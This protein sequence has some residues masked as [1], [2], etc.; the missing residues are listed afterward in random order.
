MQSP[1]RF[2]PELLRKPL[3]RRQ[4]VVTLLR[5]FALITYYVEPE[6]IRPILHPRFRPTLI[7]TPQGPRALLSVVPFEDEG[8]HFVGLPFLR[9]HF[10]QTNYRI[11]VEDEQTGEQAVWFL[12]TTLASWTVNIPHY[13]W[14]LPWH[15]AKM[16]FTCH[17]DEKNRR[18][19]NYR[20]ST[21]SDWASAELS[22]SDSG[23]PITEIAG[24]DDLEKG[25]ITLT[26]PLR[27]YY[28]RRDGQLGGYNIW[29]DQLHL[30]YG[31]AIQA[32]FGL[33]DRLGLVARGDLSQ[34]HSVMLQP[35]T[36]FAIYLPPKR[37]L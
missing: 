32:E 23:Q 14:K 28:W 25:L 9:W 26:H 30:T 15:K 11:Y 20:V 3:L 16:Q 21:Q 24:F 27:G 17:Y 5:H 6:K 12:G 8:F 34:I 19:T 37:I 13:L 31:E 29:H 36:E 7:E 33:P 18:Y 35:L 2:K 22:L 4:D 10:G 1:V